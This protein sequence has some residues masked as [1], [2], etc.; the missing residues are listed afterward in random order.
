MPFP[1]HSSSRSGSSSVSCKKLGMIPESPLSLTGHI[2]SI[3]EP[4]KCCPQGS[5]WPLPLP[6]TSTA[7]MPG[8]SQRLLL[9][10]ITH[11]LPN[12]SFCFCSQPLSEIQSGLMQVIEIPPNNGLNSIHVNLSL[13]RGKQSEAKRVTLLWSSER[14]EPRDRLSHRSATSAHDIQFLAQNGCLN[15]G[16][17]IC[18]LASRKK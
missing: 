1:S 8:L 10:G 2:Q 17:C 4:A 12:W 6:H 14:P 11:S 3:R 9:P 7:A 13:S 16:H 18:I 15:S 5:L